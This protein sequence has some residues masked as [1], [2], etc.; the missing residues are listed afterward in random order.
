MIPLSYRETIL[1][2]GL[3]LDLLVANQIVVEFKAV[4][5]VLPVHHSQ[6]LTYMRLANKPIGLLVNFNTQFLKDGVGRMVL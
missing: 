5:A 3:R 1:D 6:L 2:S 4:E